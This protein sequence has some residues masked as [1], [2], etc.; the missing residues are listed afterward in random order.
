MKEAVIVYPHQLFEKSPAPEAV[1]SGTNEVPVY[2]VE[3]PLLLTLNPIHRQKLILHK[4]SLDAY[5]TKLLSAGHRVFRLTIEEHPTTE[6]VFNRL[7]KDGV[8]QMH[9]VD[10]TDNYLEQA[11]SKSGI[12][13]IWHESPLFILEKQDA[14]ERFKKSK[15]FMANFYKE[16]R[17]D[18]NIL[19]DV[20]QKPVGGKWSF[21]E[22]NRQKIPKDAELPADIKFL[23]DNK[24]TEATEWASNVAAEQYGEAGCWLPYTHEAAENFLQE[25][26]RCRFE[27]FGQYEDAMTTDGIRL[28]HSTLSPLINIGLLTPQHVLDEALSYAEKHD[29]PINSVEGFVRQILGWREFI[30][31]SYETDGVAMRNSNFFAH[32]NPLPSSFWNGS[33]DIAPIDTSITRALQYG[34]THHIERL[35]IMGNFML[36]NQ[37]HPDEVYRWFMGLYIDA[38]DWVMVPNI[39]GMSQFAD[40]G[41]FA[42]KPYISGANY[43]KKMSDYDTGDWEDIWTALYWNFIYI[44]RKVFENNYRLSMM[45]RMLDKMTDEKRQKHLSIAKEYLANQR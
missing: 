41:S 26:F 38:Y 40:G 25:F 30:R 4:L 18:K 13:R 9:I 32:T 33:T 43:V 34:Y 44:H 7:K 11:I 24:V 17:K 27:N 37:I 23:D 20:D 1:A 19:V 14:I 16:L 39:Y 2:L 35:M 12:E 29:T 36:L 28:W 22:N 15:R 45:P 42:T 6:D 5:E 10:T 31:A 3:E 21:D 8:E